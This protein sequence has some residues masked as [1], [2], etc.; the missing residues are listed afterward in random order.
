MQELYKSENQNRIMGRDSWL[1]MVDFLIKYTNY[2]IKTNG[3][4]E[5][6]ET[7]IKFDFEKR[8]KE[9]YK[10][11][12][13]ENLEKSFG[14][15]KMVF[16]CEYKRNFK[17]ESYI[18][19]LNFDNRKIV[20]KFRLSNHKLPVEVLRY[21]KIK[22]EKRLCPICELKQKGNENHYI[23]DCTNKEIK[24]VRDKF[25]CNV[26]NVAPEFKQ[27]N[28]YN[29]IRYC[30]HMGDPKLHYITARFIDNLLN[31]FNIENDKRV[32]DIYLEI[33]MK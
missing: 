28:D 10:E 25:V 31:T 2:T 21:D 27:L 20:A 11:N 16:I 33:F 23:L 4:D 9:M 15:S 12:W 22:T 5:D 29:I 19:N 8:I 6:K 30:M 1:K 32:N 13:K 24:Y 17:F 18:D 26:I 3:I 14:E 7:N